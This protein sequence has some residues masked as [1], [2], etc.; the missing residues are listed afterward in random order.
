MKKYLSK[1]LMMLVFA[2]FVLPLQ[3][4]LLKGTID[5]Y[6]EDNVTIYYVSPLDWISFVTKDV[7][8]IDGKFTFDDNIPN[9]TQDV[10]IHLNEGTVAVRLLKGKTQEVF[11]KIKDDKPEAIF[12]GP[13]ADVNRVVA[14][15][16]KIYDVMHYYSKTPIAEL[17]K[18][19]DD[20]HKAIIPLLK[21]IK[22]KNER[23][24]YTRLNDAKHKNIVYRLIENRI[25]AEKADRENDE[26]LWQLINNVDFN[27]DA[28]VYSNLSV[29]VLQG[30]PKAKFAFK[31]D[32]GPFCHELMDIVNEKVSHPVLRRQMTALIA[33]MYFRY[34][35]DTGD[36]HAFYNDLI[37][38]AGKENEEIPIQYKSQ[39]ESW[40]KTKNGKMAPDVTLTDIY[41]NQ[42]NLSS[43]KGKLTFIDV[44]A[45]WCGPCKSEIPFMK[46]LVEHFKDN[47]KVQFV[48][49]SVDENVKAWKEMI[50]R[51]KPQW[52]QYNINGE[53]S[54]MFKNDWGITGIPRFIL[55]DKEGRIISSDTTRPSDENT[56]L[57][58]E[59]HIQ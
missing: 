46:E 29:M 41:G 34:G 33:Q 53:T 15:M 40:D 31:S 23:A 22:N 2:A 7:P 59:T 51:D 3:A 4:Q 6:Q 26:E 14:Q 45:T 38:F 5:N 35:G 28:S 48:S 10:E 17:R 9:N 44:W 30:L 54:K 18:E 1:I 13:G 57:L 56:A 11:I 39:I 36:Y 8:V 25:K 42:I 12:K 20:G 47:D 27:D 19:V 52:A 16:G 37:A 24:Y 49:I 58:I 21:K 32:M 55:I 43:L 50:E